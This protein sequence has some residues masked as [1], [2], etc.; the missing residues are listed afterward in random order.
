VDLASEVSRGGKKTTVI[1]IL[2][3]AKYARISFKE[4]GSVPT[5]LVIPRVNTINRL[6]ITL[7]IARKKEIPK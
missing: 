6:R 3:S 1:F 7:G 5:S 4:R 2:R